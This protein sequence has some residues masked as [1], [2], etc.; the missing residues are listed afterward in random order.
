MKITKTYIFLTLL[1][2]VFL[3]PLSGKA[4]TI[5]LETWNPTV[6]AGMTAGVDVWQ[7]YNFVQDYTSARLYGSVGIGYVTEYWMY[8]GANVYLSSSVFGA[9]GW[10]VSDNP[11]GIGLGFSEEFGIVPGSGI[12]VDGA[13]FCAYVGTMG[14][15]KFVFSGTFTGIPVNPILETL[16]LSADPAE[17][18]F[19]GGSTNILAVTNKSTTVYFEVDG[20]PIGSV[21]TTQNGDSFEASVSWDGKIS[22]VPATSGIH[23][24]TGR[25]AMN[26]VSAETVVF[27]LPP[28]N[29]PSD[30][31]D[32][33]IGIDSGVSDKNL[34]DIG[35]NNPEPI[36][37][38]TVEWPQLAV[39]QPGNVS[40]IL[41][42]DPVNIAYGNFVHFETD[43]TLKGKQSLT[44]ARIYNSLDSNIG[45][46]G[47]GWSFPYGARLEFNSGEVL[48][49]NSD[50]SRVRFKEQLDGNGYSAPSGCPLTLS[51]NADTSFWFIKH[52]HGDQWSFK[53]D[54]CL[55]RIEQ[56]C[57][58]NGN[59]FVECEY[60]ENNMLARVV[61][62][63]GQWLAFTHNAQGRILTA[64]DSSDRIFTYNYDQNDRLV[65]ATNPIGQ[66]TTY[67]Y[68]DVGFLSKIVKPGNR[69]VSVT[70]NDRRVSM[71]CDASGSVSHFVWD[72]TLNQL[73]LKDP[74]NTER[75]YS[76]SPDLK[77]ES[78]SIPSA[79]ATRNFVVTEDGTLSSFSDTQGKQTAFT[80]TS[81]GLIETHTDPTG[82][83]TS[84]E[85]HPTTR[86]L[87]KKTDPLGRIWSYE[88]CARS[89]LISKTDPA[90]NVTR[91]TYDSHNNRTSVTDSLGRITRYVYDSTGNYMLQTIDAM[92]GVASFTY[93]A[94][95]NLTSS[96]DTLGRTT[97]YAYDLLDRLTRSSYSDGR[98][99][100]ISYD[101]AGNIASRID[102]LSRVTAYTYDANGRLLTTTRADGTALSHAYDAAGRKTSSTDALGRVTSY[103]YDAL[104]NMIKVTYPD[105]SF[106]T[107]AY[108][109]EKRL[110]SST[111]ELGNLTAYEYDPMGRMLAMI[112]PAGSRYEN[113]YDVAGRKIAAKDPLGRTTAYEYDFLDHVV[114]TTAPNLTTNTSSYDALGNLLISTNALN[115]QTTFEYDSLNRQIK[116][117]RADGAQFTTTYDAAGQVIAETDALGNSTSHAYDIAGRRISSTNALNHLWQFDYDNAGRL[118][119]TTDPLNKTATMTYDVMDRVI[120]ESDTLG[121][122]TAYEYDA[123]GKRLARTDAMGHRSIFV[124][125]VRDRL[126]TEVDGEGR[127]VSHGYDTAG[128][129][130]SLTDGAGRIWR[131]VYDALGRVTAEIDPLGNEV[132][133]SYD[134]IGNLILKTNAR[135]QITGYEYDLMNRLV[136]LNYPDT[137]VATF[138]YDALGRELIRSGSAG[139]VEKT[140]DIAGNLISERFVNQNKA[141][142]YSFDLMGNRI[143]AV[144]PENENFK[145]AYDKLYR[146]IELDSGKAAEKIA[147]SYDALGRT[148]EEK[149]TDSTTANSFDTAGQLLEMKHYKL[150]LDRNAKNCGKNKK[151]K[152]K[153]PVYK[154]EILAL[155]Q[156]TYDLAGNRIS[157]SDENGK[158]TSYA[159]D[160]SNWLTQV[161]YPNND[162]VAYT[163]NGAGD[164]LSEKLNNNSAIAYAYDAAGRLSEKGNEIFSYDADGN[165]LSDAEATYIWNSDNRLIRVEKTID[166]CKHEK[167]RKGYGF[168][169]LKHDKEAVTYEEYAYL[170]QDWRR[171]TRKAGKYSFKTDRKGNSKKNNEEKQTF[172]SIYDGNDESHE[173]LLSLVKFKLSGKCRQNKEC[174]KLFREFVGGPAVDDTAHTR[175]GRLSF[176]M[177]KD[178]LGST[179]ALTGR[180]GKAIAH[181]GYDAWGNFRYVGKDCKS[182]CNDDD[183]DNYL[184]RLEGIRGFGYSNHNGWAFGK[185]FGSKLTPYLY[186]GRRFS[187]FTG[188]YFNRNR[189]YSP[190]LG[191]F[192][193][194]DPIG[195]NGGINL[196]RY[197]D[198]NPMLF[199]DP[200]GLTA[201][202]CGEYKD[203]KINLIHIYNGT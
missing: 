143:Q 178:G 138:G 90:G 163:Y 106:Q 125:D 37:C 111:D 8:A 16:S 181:I 85:Y 89:N 52:P 153:K 51:F 31:D 139:V 145:Y 197:A 203:L 75:V 117:T 151:G 41:L 95:G 107:Y 10:Y 54:G 162:V 155:R 13:A 198:N 91:Y 122:V 50:G 80:F 47:L 9:V 28:S 100:Q 108:D 165:M 113:Q 130:V 169:H 32:V 195:F 119:K 132:K 71:L 12:E 196:Y 104:D 112:D 93:D 167:D 124:Y 144:S 6:A 157:M 23:I 53:E 159:Y 166:G 5:V 118:V 36:T 131:W 92:G 74:L 76:F 170:P 81:D 180:D 2:V 19:D 49:V 120:S 128:R 64:K 20:Q 177:L 164:R 7:T 174:L 61:S 38:P 114:K 88:W 173:Y 199:I 116:T 175:Y 70:Y 171:I 194:K 4:D 191:R 25:T 65:S 21:Q 22:G 44:L 149:R 96:A 200:F 183:F 34:E 129:K 87:T 26:N 179:I 101:E 158:A 94:R 135:A 146:L 110:V 105:Q 43:L 62:S 168:G 59:N 147:Y 137:T 148:I 150:V 24:I 72:E 102:N 123:G 201:D 56:A 14:I 69:E 161:G 140:Y 127:I 35:E 83:I 115:Q 134:A 29:P 152:K 154:E 184:D 15:A 3:F 48:F 57:C 67:Q 121:R 186:T 190:A 46:F 45:Q 193:S 30:V 86:K 18:A 98:F 63:N 187:S 40:Q 11:G 84:Y 172:V 33:A 176:A 133:N 27:V 78:C 103:D 60:S 97:S 192:I 82:G 39:R 73:V 189:Y 160:N 17:I 185:H 55:I 182:P 99:T 66:I 42:S 141:W 142:N 136:K 1:I 202:D 109:T 126:T 58:G 188:Q 79:N 68:D 77:I 156:Y